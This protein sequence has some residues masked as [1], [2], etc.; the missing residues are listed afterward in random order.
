VPHRAPSG[1]SE[2]KPA[3]QRALLALQSKPGASLT[4]S[5]YERLASVGRSQSA[6]DLSELVAAGLVVRVGGGRSTRYVLAHE[7][8]PQRRWTPDRIRREL[9]AFC[10]KRSTWPTPGE[11]KS[12][13]HSDLY[14]AASRYGGVAYWTKALGLERIDRS[15][16]AATAEHTRSQSRLT[17]AFAGALAGV[18]LAAVTATAV[19]VSHPFG[20]NGKTGTRAASTSLSTHGAGLKLFDPL[21]RAA[22][23]TAAAH[24]RSHPRTHVTRPIARSTPEVQSQPAQRITLVSNTIQ[25]ASVPTVSASSTTVSTGSDSTGPTPLPAPPG[26]SAPSPLKAP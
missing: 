15:R 20:S 22:D 25:A 12:A 14:V 11:F 1:K 18:T 17:W 21:R 3:Q 23:Q 13:G 24:T 5:E 6:H 26:A 9:E 10:A 2:L 8:A 16:T 4:R 19:L 7:S